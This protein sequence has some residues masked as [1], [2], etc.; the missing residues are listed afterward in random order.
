VL[1]FVFAA[2][3]APLIALGMFLLL[4][5]GVGVRGLVA[6][7]G[8]LLAIAVPAWRSRSARR[9]GAATTRSTPSSAS[10][11]TGSRSRR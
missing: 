1:G 3:A 2:R 7:A 10:R 5:R 9:T 6:A 8:A 4:W 11:R